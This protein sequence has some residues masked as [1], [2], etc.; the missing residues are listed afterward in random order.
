MA[1]LAEKYPEQFAKLVATAAPGASVNDEADAA[2]LAMLQAANEAWAAKL[3]AEEAKKQEGARE[4]AAA[5]A[6][7]VVGAVLIGFGLW[8]KDGALIEQGGDLVGLGAGGL[9]LARSAPKM[10]DA[11]SGVM[12][13]RKAAK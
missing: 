4:T 3:A 9:M 13:K 2:N 1:T 6:A 12:A 8:Q 11:L 5:W 7:K 10:M